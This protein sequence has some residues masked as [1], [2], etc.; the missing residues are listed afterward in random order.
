MVTIAKLGV[1]LEEVI[2]DRAH[3]MLDVK[4]HRILSSP[5]DDI[6]HAPVSLEVLNLL[7]RAD[8]PLQQWATA[9]YSN[10]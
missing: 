4:F 5:F 1:L 10:I 8:V 3:I 6:W 9:T 2:E 7:R